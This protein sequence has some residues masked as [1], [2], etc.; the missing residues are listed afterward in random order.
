[1]NPSPPKVEHG[2]RV[3]SLDGGGIR[4]AFTASF[5]AELEEAREIGL[6][7]FFDLIAGTSTGAIIAAGI[8][9]NI[10]AR[11]ICELYKKH[12]RAIFAKRWTYLGFF[13]SKYS[14]KKLKQ[15]LEEVFQDRTLE[16]ASTRLLIPT[17]NLTSEPNVVFKTAHQPG[18][19]RDRDRKIVDVLLA[20]TAAPTYFPQAKLNDGIYADGGLWANNPSIV[21]YV[22]AAK[23]LDIVTKREEEGKFMLSDV[24]L[25]SVGTGKSSRSFQPNSFET[26]GM[27]WGTNF[28]LLD[29]MGRSQSAGNHFQ[30]TYLLGDNY[31][32]VDFKIPDGEKWSLDAVDK[33][34]DLLEQGRI[35]AEAEKTIIGEIF[36]H[37]EKRQFVPY[38]RVAE[39]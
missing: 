16:D 25:L 19:K 6:S 21:A 14:N 8:A 2:F 26:G 7:S 13:Q 4:G 22:E 28:K 33:L 17:V 12:G 18:F 15:A 32:R 34:P 20:T 30:A 27:W 36:L 24:K 10:P 38:P 29:V 1:M 3:L 5:L 39:A 31:R 37:S 23:I 35:Q 11:R 9:C